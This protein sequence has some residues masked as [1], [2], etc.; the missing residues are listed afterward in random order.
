M[1]SNRAMSGR[2]SISSRDQDQIIGKL[3]R[4]VSDCCCLHE[5]RRLSGREIPND[6]LLTV[7]REAVDMTNEMC[8]RAP[9]HST[10]QHAPF[11]WPSGSHCAAMLRSRGPCEF[12][13]ISGR[14][15]AGEAC[16]CGGILPLS[17]HTD[18]K[19]SAGDLHAK[20]L[21]CSKLVMLPPLLFARLLPAR[22]LLDGNRLCQRASDEAPRSESTD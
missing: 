4:I 3:R 22:L 16:I 10:S 13:G 8:G 20:D 5:R 14:C 7:L 2:S 19:L 15:L 11:Q 9:N 17:S 1:G 6:G 18:S 21:L 12:L